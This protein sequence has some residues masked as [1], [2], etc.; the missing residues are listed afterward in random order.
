MMESIAALPPEIQ[1]VIVYKEWSIKNKEGIGK[2]IEMKGKVHNRSPYP[3]HKLAL[4]LDLL[5]SRNKVLKRLPILVE[6]IPSGGTHNLAIDAEAHKDLM[7]YR[8]MYKAAR[9]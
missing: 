8:L 2:F 1:D 6:R 4:E 3:V 5:D 7:K 9:W